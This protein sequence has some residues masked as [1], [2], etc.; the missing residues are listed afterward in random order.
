MK[1]ELKKL[2]EAIAKEKDRTKALEIDKTLK[3][4][5]KKRK[6]Q[7]H[8]ASV[9]E[10]FWGVFKS[11][12]KTLG[13]EESANKS[14]LQQLQ[15]IKKEF[16]DVTPLILQDEEEVVVESALPDFFA[17]IDPAKMSNEFDIRP[18][19]EISEVT[20][21]YTN[22]PYQLKDHPIQLI[23]TPVEK[24]GVQDPDIFGLESKVNKL[25][26]KYSGVINKIEEGRVSTLFDEHKSADDVIAELLDTSA[27]LQPVETVDKDERNLQELAVNYLKEKKKVV[28]EQVDENE[29]LQQ[30]ITGINSHIRQLILGMQGI[31]G[32]G[33]VR[34]EFL[35][36]IDRDTAKVN[37]KFLQYNATSKKWVGADADDS[38]VPFSA[39]TSRPTTLSGYGIT[40]AVTAST[41]TTFT[42]KTFDADAT[43]NSLTNIEDDNIKAGAEINAT[44]IADG[45]VTNTEFQ[46]ISTLSSNAQTQIS[47]KIGLTGLAISADASASGSG[48]ISYNNS[49][50]QF[51]YT[52]PDLSSYAAASNVSNVTNESKATMFTSAALTGTPTAPTATAATNTTQIATTA[53]TTTAVANLLDSA[54]ATLNTLNELA[55]ALGDD[56]AFSTTISNSIGLKAPLASPALTGTPSAPTASTGTNTTQLATTAYVKQEIDALKALLYAYDQS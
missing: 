14:K 42:N 29:G 45:S 50:G 54:P 12:L 24:S 56:A 51:T 21:P 43:G 35:D 5:A 4:V 18:V 26:E 44:K 37:G 10:D 7:D 27:S 8:S 33:E 55:A 30:Q 38:D 3:V 17:D 48:G 23:E 47:S 28:K 25:E 11:Q 40:D 41:T 22:Q 13:E 53:F 39:V 52:P 9:K 2:F 20:L 34:L 16:Q 1:D 36:D 31:G 6:K 15:E 19:S 32:G 49:N 46:Y